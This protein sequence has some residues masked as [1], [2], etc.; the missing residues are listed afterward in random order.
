MTIAALDAALTHGLNALAGGG[1][2]PDELAVAITKGGIP[3]M[4]LAV[5]ARWW[6]G[7]DRRRERHV[8]VACGLSFLGGLLLNQ[9]VL[10]AVSRV[11]P[12]DAGVTHLLIDRSTD[13]S[14][15]SDHATAGFAI[16]ACLALRRLYPRATLFGIAALAI[17]LSRV[18]VGTHYFGDILGG[19]ATACLAAMLVKLAY[20]P[21]TRLDRLVTGIF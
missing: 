12:Y 5:A 19:A 7:A 18:Y 9:A 15:P 2:W 11:R 10:L 6:A 1:A 3:L 17:A 4:V 13:P 21:D 16:V 20:R 8:A 14:F